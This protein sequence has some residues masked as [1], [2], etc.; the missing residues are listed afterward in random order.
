MGKILIIEDNKDLQEALE[1]KLRADG[2]QTTTVATSE[3]G[4]KVVLSNKPNVI[5]LDVITRSLHASEFLR[6]LKELG[7][8][9]SSCKVIVLTNLD[10]EITR[11]KVSEY[12]I[13]AFLVKAES[14]L[15]QISTTVNEALLETE[16]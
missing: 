13:D 6:R 3:L 7:E 8:E 1:T 11:K 14:S 15:E 9:Y 4:L 10:N 12:N 5:L 16:S 2:H